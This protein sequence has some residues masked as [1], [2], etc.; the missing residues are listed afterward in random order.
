[1]LI[2]VRVVV[3]VAQPTAALEATAVEM[4][5]AEAALVASDAAAAA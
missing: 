3:V 5:V 4:V 2:G 1:M